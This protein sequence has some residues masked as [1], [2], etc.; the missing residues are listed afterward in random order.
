M[1]KDFQMIG[2]YLKD[3]VENVYEVKEREDGTP[4]YDALGKIKP[5]MERYD[6]FESNVYHPNESAA[7]IFAEMYL[8]DHLFDSTKIRQDLIDTAKKKFERCRPYFK[9]SLSLKEK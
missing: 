7:A 9:K 6:G 5:Y 3:P 2:V 8:V 4:H 1:P